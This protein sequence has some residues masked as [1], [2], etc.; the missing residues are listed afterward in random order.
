M[1][2]ERKAL[3]QTGVF[4]PMRPDEVDAAFSERLDDAIARDELYLAWQPQVD[5]TDGRLTGFEALVR[6]RLSDGTVVPPDVFVPMAESSGAIHRLGEWVLR[7]ACVTSAAWLRDGV[8]D[9]P[10]SVNLSARQ[11]EAPDLA[12][13][14]LGVL[15]DTRVPAESLKLELT[16]TALFEHGDAARQSL[17]ELRGAGVRLVLDDFGTGYSSLTLLRRVPV[18]SLKIDKHFIQAM[19]EDRDA[20]AIVHA[21][22]ALAHA[23]GLHVVAEGVET[24]EQLLFLRAYRCDRVQGYLFARPLPADEVPGFIA[25]H[26]DRPTGG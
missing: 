15:A 6:W 19:V 3:T 8:T 10:V 13:T 17:L 4:G 2:A 26:A 21:V 16:E 20:A 5:T 9:V 11:L 25:R 1:A 18:D 7:R 14:V 22:I 23:L 24:M 12:R